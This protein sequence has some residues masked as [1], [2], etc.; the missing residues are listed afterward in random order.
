MRLLGVDEATI[1]DLAFGVR[2]SREVDA[3]DLR[4]YLSVASHAA[5]EKAE[6]RMAL[7]IRRKQIYSQ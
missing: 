1:E 5:D 2:T 3:V 6:W 4:V 7:K